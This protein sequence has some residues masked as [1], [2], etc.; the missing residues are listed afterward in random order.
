MKY[1]TIVALLFLCAPA[2]S[3]VNRTVPG[4]LFPNAQVR[5]NYVKNPNAEVNKLSI[6]D[7]S[8]IV[9]RNTSS[10]LFDT[11]DF[12]IDA[13]SS[14]QKVKWL[15][16]AFDNGVNGNCA[17]SF[18]VNGDASLYKAYVEDG[19]GNKKSADLQLGNYSQSTQVLI[20][21]P[22][23]SGIVQV[24]EATGNGAVIKV[25]NVEV[26]L[27]SNITVAVPQN[28][29]T[30][31]VASAGTVTDE[32]GGDWINGSCT[33]SG[34][35]NSTATCT[36][37][38]G[39]F[40]AIPTCVATPNEGNLRYSIVGAASAT[41]VV[42]IT[43]NSA[44]TLS[45]DGFNISCS[46]SGSDYVQNAITAQNYDFSEKTYTPGGSWN[47][48][49]TYAGKVA[50]S[51]SRALIQFTV[52]LTGA[53]N[54]VDLTMTSGQLL[55]GLGVTV[56]TTRLSSPS[57]DLQ[58]LGVCGYEDTGTANR[59]GVTAYWSMTSALLRF[60]SSG[61]SDITQTQPITWA[62]GDSISC[63]LAVPITEWAETQNAPQLLGSVTSNATSAMRFEGAN[64]GATGTVTEVGGS[65][66]ISGNCTNANPRVCTFSTA[67]AATPVCTATYANAASAFTAVITAQGTSSVSVYTFQTDAPGAGSAQPFNILCLGP[68]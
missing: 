24:I 7:A 50:R 13:A 28:V 63:Q 11:A 29:F 31:K 14:T 23:L 42:F 61:A 1:S 65:D 64:V 37:N 25:D 10:P 48:N 6:T 22:C 44:G 15:T 4:G 56:D 36:F 27:A 49:V 32:S 34:T 66:W 62:N 40:S 30:A 33:R 59:G 57:G 35:S 55:N 39:V 52:S 12:S 67:Y 18:F 68:R 53:P 46:K 3:Q 45:S 20:N 9:T 16:S 19:S 60:P 47:T 51:G 21:F 8:S 43:A 58:A 54:A 41:S 5:K 2:F 26:G 38:S 17:A